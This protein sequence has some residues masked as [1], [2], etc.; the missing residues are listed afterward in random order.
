M[1]RKSITM[2]RQGDILLTAIDRIPRQA[3]LKKSNI[4]L[5]GEETGHTHRLDN[6]EL[7]ILNDS[8]RNTKI[9]VDAKNG[10][11][12]LSHEEHKRIDLK[13]NYYIVTRQ[14]E[15]ETTPDSYL[16]IQDDE[17]NQ[18]NQYRYIAD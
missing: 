6:G 13:A 8:F 3:K 2:Y 5:E 10:N 7:Y 12:F 17:F 11:S 18:Y 1:F 9:Y 16:Y 14:R 15:Y 4:I